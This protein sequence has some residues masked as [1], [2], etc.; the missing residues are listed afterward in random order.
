MVAEATSIVEEYT[1]LVKVLKA[2]PEEMHLQAYA[3]TLSQVLGD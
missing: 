2:G 3:A 1:A